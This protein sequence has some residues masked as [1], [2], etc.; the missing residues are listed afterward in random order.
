[1]ASIDARSIYGLPK[2]RITLFQTNPLSPREI[3]RCSSGSFMRGDSKIA[4]VSA[5]GFTPIIAYEN[6]KTVYAVARER[7]L[8]GERRP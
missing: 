1:M 5:L 3:W 4:V 7:R 8:R 2:P 6:W